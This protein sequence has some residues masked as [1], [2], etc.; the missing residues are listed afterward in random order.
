ME[1]QAW[2]PD[3]LKEE[4]KETLKKIE[5][6]VNKNLLESDEA[7]ERRNE[8]NRKYE[9]SLAEYYDV[10]K[11]VEQVEE[12]YKNADILFTATEKISFYN[13]VLNLNTLILGGFWFWKE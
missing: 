4:R 5:E 6:E 2:K 1:G 9:Y 3:L 7:E 10:K 12:K 11:R 13:Y 8:V